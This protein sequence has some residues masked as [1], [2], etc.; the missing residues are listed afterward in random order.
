[1]ST[2]TLQIIDP[3]VGPF[4]AVEDIRAWLAELRDFPDGESRDLAVE[5]AE[6]WLASALDYERERVSHGRGDEPLFGK[7][8]K[9]QEECSP[10]AWG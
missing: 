2:N 4:S 9:P 1:M 10:R 6:A 8:G 3:P 7:S 5:Q